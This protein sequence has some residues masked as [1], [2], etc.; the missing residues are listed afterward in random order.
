[1]KNSKAAIV[2]MASLFIFLAAIA[3]IVGLACR[4]ELI[5]LSESNEQMAAELSNVRQKIYVADTDIKAGEKISMD[6]KTANIVLTQMYCSM[7]IDLL[8]ENDAAG[9]AQTEIPK[10]AIILKSMVAES[11]PV[12]A[13]EPER[14]VEEVAESFDLPYKIEAK[15]IDKKGNELAEPM[16]IILSKQIGEQELS[17]FKADIEGFHLQSIKIGK[18]EVWSFGAV[19]LLDQGNSKRM[20]Y[21]YTDGT[22]LQRTEITDNMEVTFTYVKGDGVMESAGKII[23]LAEK[24]ETETSRAVQNQIHDNVESGGSAITFDDIL[25]KTES[26]EIE[27][28]N[29]DG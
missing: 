2:T 6:G 19:R 20:V 21:Y 16:Q 10:G 22:G 1:M 17:S 13:M 18:E 12:T 27:G 4:K 7:D 26:E 11:A 9:F 14:I 28:G 29:I 23:G 3:I 5:Y 8:I 15:Y 24:E 25:N